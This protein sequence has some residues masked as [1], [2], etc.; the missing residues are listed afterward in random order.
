MSAP[1]QNPTDASPV[2]QAGTDQQP[3]H[4][5]FLVV[6]VG[7]SSGSL[8]AFRELLEGVPPDAG[9]CFLFVQHLQTGHK[10]LLV[11]LLRK[12]T[13]L[14]VLEAEQDLPLQANHVYVISPDTDMAIHDGRLALTPR[15]GRRAPHMPV[16]HLFRSLAHDQKSRAVGV[17]L[18]GGG[19]DGTLGLKAIKAEDGITFAQDERSARHDSMPRSATAEGY[20]DYVLPPREIAGQL[21]RIAR[22]PY[23]V[24]PEPDGEAGEFREVLDRILAL[25]RAH[26][27]V[28]FTRYKRSTITRRVRR[29]MALRSLESA[30][31]YLQLLETDPA[32]VQSLYQDCL[33]RVTRFFRDEEVFEVLKESVFPALIK[34][35][36]PN[37]AIRIWVAGCSTGEEVYSLAI[38]L[39]EFLGERNSNLPIKILATDVNEAALEKARAGMYIDN[40]ELDVSPERLR[41]FFAKLNGHYQIGKAVRDTCVFSKHD[42]TSDPPFS[43]LDLVSCRNVLIYLDG[44]LQKRVLPVLHYSL[45]PGGYLLL[46]SSETIGPFGELFTVVDQKHRVYSKNGVA[47]T[48]LALDFS[49]YVEAGGRHERGAPAGAPWSALEVQKE[50]DRVVLTRYAPVGVVI[51]E[52]MTVLQFRGRTGDY[53]EPAPGMASLDLLKMLREGLLGELRAA[54]ARAKAE[55]VSVRK[56]NIPLRHRD[57]FRSVNLEVIPIKVPPSGVR[58]FV[59]LFQDAPDRAPTP[60]GEAVSAQPERNPGPVE[61]QVHQLQQELASTREYLQSLVEEHES[62][63]EELKSASE[64]L[65][66]SNEELQSTN[67]ELQTAKEETQS[68]NEEL[69]TLNDELQHRNFDL[70]L[71]NNDMI[72]L[73]GAVQ[74]PIVLVSRDLRIRRFTP[75]AEKLLNLIPTDVGRPIGDIKPNLNLEDLDRRIAGVI[76]TLTP[77]EMETQ[78]REGRWY[79]LRIRPYVTLEGKIEGASVTLLDVDSLKRRGS[80][81]SRPAPAEGDGEAKQGQEHPP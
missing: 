18:S 25:L 8:E 78:D 81:T 17:V 72:N 65:L 16:D 42:L 52:S 61:Q 9:I 46:G 39:L 14:N 80:E 73:F 48:P 1:S 35:R 74:I 68:A 34:D 19:T 62:A 58:C 41:R 53:L 12:A 75:T 63:C 49:A 59:I 15:G 55:G 20:V 22:H 37:A 4:L 23:T 57:H 21:L 38:C 67:E 70:A 27:D 28:D 50:A 6:G 54:I 45:N 30:A 36:S 76:D 32:E 26:T 60:G 44:S 3:A 47:P 56:E 10:S 11:E 77:L 43:R 79:V 31:D 5:P 13:P 33:I 51:D 66:S 24:Q 40:I 29:R 7:G 71:A 69:A 2:P 64:E